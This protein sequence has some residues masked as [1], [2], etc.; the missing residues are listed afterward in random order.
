MIDLA[1]DGGVI[2]G[3]AERLG[4]RDGVAQP[5]HIA[6]PWREAV[7]AGGR[8]RKPVIIEARDGL[9]SGD[10]QWALANSVPRVARRS[11]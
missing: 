5:G 7:N 1:G 11:M 3:A 8:G 4:Q 9:Q 10:W 6:E 2:S